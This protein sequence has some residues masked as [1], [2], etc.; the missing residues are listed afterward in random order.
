MSATVQ[1]PEL[2][3]GAARYAVTRCGLERGALSERSTYNVASAV[4]PD[5]IV[6][7]GARFLSALDEAVHGAGKRDRVDAPCVVLA[8]GR[9]DADRQAGRLVVAGAAAAEEDGVDLRLALVAEQR[10]YSERRAGSR[11][12]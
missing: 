6:S 4:P 9:Q 10:P 3:H 12:T 7:G 5:G 2:V 11:T 8:E 1:P